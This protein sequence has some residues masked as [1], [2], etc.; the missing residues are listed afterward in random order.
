MVGK[1]EAGIPEDD[2]RNPATIADNVG[3]NVGD[4]AGM[5]ADLFETYA[6]TTVATMVLASIFFAADPALRRQADDVPAG[7]RRRLH[8][9]LDH[10]HLL[11]SPRLRRRHHVGDVQGRDRGRRA[12]D[13]GHLVRHRL[14][15]RHG[16]GAQGRRPLVHRH[17]AVLVLA[18]RP[19]HHRPDRVDH[20][21]LHRH[22]LPSGQ[23]RGPG[24]GHRPRHQR[25]RGPRDVDG[26]HGAAGPADL[27]RHRDLLRAGRPVRHR[28][29]HD[30]H[31]GARRHGGG[32]RRLRPGHR[33][34]RRHCRNGG[35]AE[36]S[37]QEH[38]RARRRRQHHQGGHQ[39]LRHRLGRPRRAGAVRGLHLGPR[40]LHRPGQ[41]RREGG[42]LLAD[43]TPTSWSAC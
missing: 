26:S 28:H 34:C 22:R 42:Q 20:R 24:L 16:H 33:Q 37:A 29:R 12:V 23:G 31:A 18:G 38:R 2:P 1:V 39:G 30:R 36:G 40:L 27:R 13:P 3:D 9:H 21:I 15:G 19:R 4:C 41:A 32:A 17:V 6:V 14:P 7:H 10:R 25:H 5:A 11:R 43:R 8:H 35:P